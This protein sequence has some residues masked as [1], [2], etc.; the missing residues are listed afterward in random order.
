MHAVWKILPSYEWIYYHNTIKE[1]AIF[2][3]P[4][5]YPT[6]ATCLLI[7]G[8]ER[9]RSSMRS[10][11]REIS[12]HNNNIECL[13][14]DIRGHG[15]SDGDDYSKPHN[16]NACVED[17]VEL[18][19]PL[20][21][22]PKYVIGFSNIGSSVA[23]QYNKFT[24]NK[25]TTSIMS[26]EVTGAGAIIPPS[27]TIVIKN[28]LPDNETDAEITTVNDTLI[29]NDL[30]IDSVNYIDVSNSVDDTTVC[31]IDGKEHDHVYKNIK[32]YL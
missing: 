24:K 6:K 22:H 13:L 19:L 16:I 17:I 12:S 20:Q 8:E 10:L 7:H 2:D 27:K 30:M 18:V 14:I 11:A 31:V 3:E 23:L 29:S 32:N 15:D 25:C 4:L 5:E 28:I 9:N 26:S 21:N 1:I